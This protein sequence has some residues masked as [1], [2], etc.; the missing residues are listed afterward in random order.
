MWHT[1]HTFPTGR[2]ECL[3]FIKRSSG[4]WYFNIFY[5]YIVYNTAHQ[6][7]L[8]NRKYVIDTIMIFFN[9]ITI[10]CTVCDCWL[11]GSLAV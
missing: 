4:M 2:S 3:E 8:E 10:G 9:P 6:H 11:A 5:P 7:T 1:V